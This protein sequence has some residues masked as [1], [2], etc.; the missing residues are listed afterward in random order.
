[1]LRGWGGVSPPVFYTGGCD[2]SWQ[3]DQIGRIFRLLGERLLRLAFRKL[4]KYVAQFSGY[5][6]HGTK[7]KNWFWGKMGLATF[8]AILSQARLVTLQVGEQSPIVQ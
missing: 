5:F 6:F 8:W 2:A 1:M 4:Q 3:G 7:I